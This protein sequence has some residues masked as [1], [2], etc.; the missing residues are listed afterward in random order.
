MRAR[1]DAE[2]GFAASALRRLVQDE[3]LPAVDLGEAIRALAAI[4]VVATACAAAGGLV[5]A[6]A[7]RGARD[8]AREAPR[9]VG[10]VEPVL[11]DLLDQVEG[12]LE[13]VPDQQRDRRAE[14]P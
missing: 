7:A 4:A 2:R 3:L 1:P 5:D 11:D 10:D 14:L 13:D 8:A 9:A 6:F 12:A